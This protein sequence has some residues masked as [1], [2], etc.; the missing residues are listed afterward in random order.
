[1][2]AKDFVNLYGSFANT[3]ER[4]TGIRA[5]FILAQAALESGWGKHAPG[6]NFFGIKA[7]KSW[8]GKT[9]LLTTTEVLNDPNAEF[10][11][12]LS[13]EQRADGKYR[14]RV[15]AYF[16][17]YDSAEE[18]FRDHAALLQRVY[19]FALPVKHD[20][21]AF[22]DRIASKYATAPDYA[23][24]LKSVIAIVRT[25]RPKP[26]PPVPDSGTIPNS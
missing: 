17:A 25:L 7:G 13:V 12:V 1:M 6:F 8:K 10:P 18:S 2:T 19:S 22:A 20:A 9:Q 3:I 24:R 4:E 14:Y 16:R 21:D 15:R 26:T 23:Q 5:V 11:E